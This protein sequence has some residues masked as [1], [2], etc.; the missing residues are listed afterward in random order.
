MCLN[1]LRCLACNFFQQFL[2]DVKV[3]VNVLHVI[4]FF[5]RLHQANHRVR[6]LTFE[7]DEVLGN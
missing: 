4:V 7:F 5:E 2:I 1:T 6:L 3:G